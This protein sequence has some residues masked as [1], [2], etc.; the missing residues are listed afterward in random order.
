MA[1]AAG[2]WV[3]D[4]IPLIED[5]IVSRSDNGIFVRHITDGWTT[6]PTFESVVVESSMYRGVMVEQYNH[7][8]YSNLPLNAIF[9]DIT[10]RG[11][12][13]P[14]AKTSGLS[15]AAF[16]INTSGVHIDI[17]LSLIHI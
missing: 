16:D 6:R 8:Q 10:V 12:G 9:N 13:G 1:I 17:G 3:E 7:S 14:G 5:S 11:T 15:V 4:S 2:I